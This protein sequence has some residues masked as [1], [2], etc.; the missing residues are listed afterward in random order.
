MSASDNRGSSSDV[1]GGGVL[2]SISEKVIRAL[3]PAF[4]LLV[5]LNIGFLGVMAW[6]YE[7]NSET[8][9]VLLTKIVDACLLD[10]KSAPP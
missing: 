1:S 7:H 4:L 2:A 9:G 5:L 6:L 10:R 8:R 3:P